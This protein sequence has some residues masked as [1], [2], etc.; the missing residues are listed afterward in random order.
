MEP[1]YPGRRPL[2][3][4][5]WLP[6]APPADNWT[7]NT[8][9]EVL[10]NG[11]IIFSTTL[12][13]TIASAGRWVAHHCKTVHLAVDWD[14]SESPPHGRLADSLVSGERLCRSPQ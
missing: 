14:H 10:S 13:Q 1:Q 3:A 12:D 9:Y 7:K 4:P 5:A 11:S 2:Y 6:A 8:I